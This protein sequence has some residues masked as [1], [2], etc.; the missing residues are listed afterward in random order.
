MELSEKLNNIEVDGTDIENQSINKN[1]FICNICMEELDNKEKC[2]TDCNHIYCSGCLHEWFNKKKNTCPS[3]R[4][5]ITNYENNN[6]KNHIIKINEGNTER[7]NSNTLNMIISENERILGRL[8]GRIFKLN[9]LICS[10]IFYMLYNLTIEEQKYG[11][12]LYYKNEYENCT[13]ILN[14]VTN[15]LGHFKD[16]F[17]YSNNEIIECKI[18]EMYIDKCT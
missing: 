14:S 8:K 2:I 9:M 4:K 12:Y 16:I 15:N 5:E 18:P 7:N 6:E 1:N 11:N 13:D 3:C 17:I 10:N